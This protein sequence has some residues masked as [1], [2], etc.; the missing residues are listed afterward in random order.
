MNLHR[1]ILLLGGITPL[2]LA[3]PTGD[4]V[5]TIDFEPEYEDLLKMARYEELDSLD[6]LGF[7]E[8]ENVF[9]N[10]PPPSREFCKECHLKCI[11]MSPLPPATF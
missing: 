4:A 9:V 5:T 7:C 3:A 1:F 10:V 8:V 2:V 11:A 6:E